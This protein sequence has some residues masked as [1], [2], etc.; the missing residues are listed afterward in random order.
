MPMDGYHIRR[1]VLR[2]QENS[3]FLFSRRGAPFTFDPVCKH[4]DLL[5][6]C[7]L[8]LSV[9]ALLDTIRGIKANNQGFVPNFN[10]GFV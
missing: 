9:I 3:E 5:W 10:H 7:I 4:C 6:R 1:S 8:M 2:E